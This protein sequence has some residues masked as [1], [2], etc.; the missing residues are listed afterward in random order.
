MKICLI[1]TVA[2]STL[3]FRKNLIELIVAQGHEIHVF[4]T[5]Y[6][7]SSRKKIQELG[8]IPVSYSLNRGGLNPLADIRSTLQLKKII[9]KISP[10]I[11]FSYFLNEQTRSQ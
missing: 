10:D 2:A 7:E 9:S 5:D 1:G 8:G 11:V 6:T 3:N 4:A